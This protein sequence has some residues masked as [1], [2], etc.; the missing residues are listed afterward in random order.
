MKEKGNTSWGGVAG[1][2]HDLLF[3]TKPTYQR[4]VILPNLLRLMDIKK[5]E[6]VLDIACGPGFFSREFAAK[7]AAVTGIDISEELIALAK[8]NVKGPSFQ[9]ASA[10]RMPLVPDASFDAA[11]IVLA[12]QNIEELKGVFAEAARVLKPGG[13]FYVVMNHPAFRVPKESSWQWD[14]KRQ[15]RRVD[16]YLSEFS[17]KI[18]MNPGA[19]AGAGETQV[20]VENTVSFHHPLQSYFKALSKT[21]FCIR[22]L[23]EW[24]SNKK[25]GSGPRV[26]A[27]NAARKEIPLFL[28]LEAIKQG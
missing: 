19:E 13:R 20:P 12:I 10:R 17:S 23:E 9:V 24:I 16:R 28:C 2:Y 15:Y 26:A 21:G 6:A 7:G 22:R 14:E 3:G 4:D 18:T 25:S 27:E 11:A 5:G 8:E 1:W